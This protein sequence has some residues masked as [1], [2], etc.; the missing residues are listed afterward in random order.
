MDEFTEHPQAIE[1]LDNEGKWVPM[2]IKGY[3]LRQPGGVSGQWWHCEDG[4][5]ERIPTLP[6]NALPYKT[7]STV[8]GDG[9][10]FWI[11]RGDATDPPEDETWHHL[12]FD[13]D[14]ETLSSSLTN[15][16]TEA[17]MRCHN[18]EKRWPGMLLP[19]IYHGPAYP[20]EGYGGLTGDL[21]IFLALIALSMNP[22]RLPIELPRMMQN[23]EWGTHGR[24]HGRT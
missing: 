1:Q 15:T 23:G 17:V 10:G 14:E 8:Y 3:N 21:P 7:F 6:A 22:N 11:L 12:R 4:A 19:D 20:Y 24:S 2:A 13:W 9:H 5:I 16:G 18:P